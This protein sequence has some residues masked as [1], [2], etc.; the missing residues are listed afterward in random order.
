MAP[1]NKYPRLALLIGV[2]VFVL[3]AAGCSASSDP[4][5]WEQAAEE[6][7][8][9]QLNFMNSC[10]Q[11]NTS[12]GGD[13]EG[14]CECSFLELREYYADDFEGFKEADSELRNDPDAIDNPAIIPVAVTEALDL[15]ATE[16]LA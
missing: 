5:S 15:C 2:F 6:G 7:G 3:V 1:R 4:D 8:K 9:I 16:H 13:V 14:Y 12:A 10:E 11:S